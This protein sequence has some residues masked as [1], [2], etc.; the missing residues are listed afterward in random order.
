MAV[1]AAG[2]GLMKIVDIT[3]VIPGDADELLALVEL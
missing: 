2:G 1:E 3:C